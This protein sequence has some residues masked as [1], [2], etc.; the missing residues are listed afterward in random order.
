MLF[1]HGFSG[2]ATTSSVFEKGKKFAVTQVRKSEQLR[3][4]SK[5]LAFVESTPDEVGKAGIRAFK[6]VYGAP[7]TQPLE[8]ARYNRFMELAG[9][10]TIVPEKLPPTEDAAYYHGLRVHHQIMTWSL[11]E[12][13]TR[14]DPLD[15]G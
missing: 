10:G 2:C 4:C 9:K 3:D 7:I 1:I 13:N 14:F 15:W 11:L 6:I 8:K 12:E 5:V